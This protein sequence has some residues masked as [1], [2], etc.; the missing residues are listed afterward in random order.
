M[1]K[2]GKHNTFFFGIGT[3]GRDM[4]YTLVS[5][6]FLTYVT[7]ALSLTVA[8]FAA[9]GTVLTVMRIFDAFNDPL[10]GV[11]VDNTR[12]RFGKFKPWIAVGA[13]FGGLLTVLMYSDFKLSG[14]SFVI[15]IAVVYL[16]W[17]I[18]YGL[19]DIA[20]WSYLPALT[21]DQKKR[22]KIGAF[23]R[24]C[25]NIGMYAVVVGLFPITN[26]L[27]GYKNQKSWFYLSLIIF[28]ALLIFQAF[29]I[30]GVKEENRHADLEDKTSL[31]Q[32]FSVL[33]KNDQLVWTAISMAL[34]MIGYC[35]TTSFGTYYFIYAYKNADMYMIFAAVL[36]VAQLAALSLFPLISKKTDRK[37]LYGIATALVVVGYV[38]FFFAPMNMLP[39]GIAGMLLFIGQ[40][41][42]QLLMLMFLADTIEYGQWKTGK[43]NESIIFSV[44]PFINKIGGALAT[45]I[46][47]VTLI[48]SGIKA[49]NGNADLVTPKSIL[50]MKLSMMILPLIMIVLGY[51]IY[52]KKYRIDKHFYDKMIGEIEARENKEQQSK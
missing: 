30:F 43:R 11:I 3:V 48:V 45:G 35:T 22:E 39:I 2:T 51:I 37:K 13:I 21:R 25:A 47:T 38:V 36:G 23:A 28:A 42:I 44:Q 4:L 26:A 8:E 24:I 52:L 49:L 27:G 19:N 5:M 50:I 7:E 9:L 15:Y 29:T 31:K 20:Y 17:D 34:F 14:N 41:M 33:F 40:A 32:M 10:A 18:M 1:N 46:V 6:Y 16:L 12:S